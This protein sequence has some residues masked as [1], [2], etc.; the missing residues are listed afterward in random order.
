VFSLEEV[1]KEV[2][3]KAEEAGANEKVLRL[4]VGAS[5]EGRPYWL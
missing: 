3:E 1:L 4:L 2:M 5:R